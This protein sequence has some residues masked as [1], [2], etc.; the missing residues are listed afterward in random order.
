MTKLTL[1]KIFISII[2]S[3]LLISSIG[4]I[5]I[6]HA[7]NAT[8]C[9]TG[10]SASTK[11][12][13]PS[14]AVDTQGNPLS[15]NNCYVLSQA[16]SLPNGTL[17]GTWANVQCSNLTTPAGPYC[18]SGSNR[19]YTSIDL[20]CSHVGGPV[21]DLVFAIIR[22]L[23]DGVGIVVVASM[24]VAGI[25]YTVSQDDPQAKKNAMGRIQSSLLALVIFI[26]AYAILNYVIP[27]GFFK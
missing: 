27:Q 13:C 5:T 9:Y 17:T 20:G 24:I 11:T 3:L 23:S 12:A 18:G 21:T 4:S 19:V 14:G 1:P 26:F 25:Q 6:A 16:N 22:L 10:T 2:A 15:S 7:S 8:G